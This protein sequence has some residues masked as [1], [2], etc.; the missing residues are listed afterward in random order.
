MGWASV[1]LGDLD[2]IDQ[3]LVK[4]D[5]LFD[6]LTEAK[7]VE[8]WEAELPPGRSLAD[9]SG[10]KNYFT[11]F[12]NIKLVYSFI[13]ETPDRQGQS[14]PRHGLPPRSRKCGRIAAESNAFR[15]GVFCGIQCFYGI[16]ESH[17]QEA[18]Q[19]K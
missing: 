9:S 17:Y 8:R 12:E 3:Y 11:L 2:R 13:P 7:A 5:Y 14:L 16:R 1:L 15:A 10:T 6:Y 4:T 18:A 19:I